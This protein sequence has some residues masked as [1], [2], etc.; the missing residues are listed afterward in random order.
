[1]NESSSSLVPSIN[2][3]KDSGVVVGRW[4]VIWGL[5]FGTGGWRFASAT[6]RWPFAMQWRRE[7]KESFPPDMRATTSIVTLE[8]DIYS[9]GW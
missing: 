1:M 8:R 7:K 3:A 9:G 5:K 4:V 6:M 2:E